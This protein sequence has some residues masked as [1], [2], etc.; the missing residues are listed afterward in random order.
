MLCLSKRP[1][2]A[3]MKG[4]KMNTTQHAPYTGP[5]TKWTVPDGTYQAEFLITHEQFRALTDKPMLDYDWDDAVALMRTYSK[6]LVTWKAMSVGGGFLFWATFEA[7]SDEQA[8]YVTDLVYETLG[9]GAAE[10]FYFQPTEQGGLVNK[11]TF[12]WATSRIGA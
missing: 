4:R 5:K 1:E 12:V 7:N 10:V 3:E 11:S 9:A 8:G 2:W 6:R